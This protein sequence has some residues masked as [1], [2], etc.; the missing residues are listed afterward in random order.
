MQYKDLYNYKCNLDEILT[1]LNSNSR[2]Q[3]GLD[4]NIASARSSRSVPN[5]PNPN[6][7]RDDQGGLLKN[8]QDQA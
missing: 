6:Q 7:I 4:M 2:C 3:I 5:N 8:L 1:R